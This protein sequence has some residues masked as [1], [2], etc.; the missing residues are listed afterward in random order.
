[1][2]INRAYRAINI[3]N[4]INDDYIPENKKKGKHN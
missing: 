3:K 1:M 2:F 4:G